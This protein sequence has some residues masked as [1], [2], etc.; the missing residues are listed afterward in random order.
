MS[1]R[2]I[3][4]R[5][6]ISE[7]TAR[8]HVQNIL[9]KLDVSTRAAAAAFAV[10]HGL[11][12]RHSARLLMF[13]QCRPRREYVGASA[14]YVDSSSLLPRR[15]SADQ[16]MCDRLRGRTMAVG[17]MRRTQP[18]DRHRQPAATEARHDL[19]QPLPR[20]RDPRRSADALHPAAC[21][22][23]GRQAGADRR[24]ERPDADLR[25]TGRRRAARGRRVWRG[26]GFRKGDVFAT[27]CP[28]VPE[29]ALAFYGVAS[30]GGATTMLN[31][32][33]TAGEMHR[34]LADSGARFV[35]TVPERLATVREAV[36]GTRVEEIFVLG[37]AEGAT[38]F[39]ALLQHDEPLP[40]VAIDPAEDVVAPALFERHDRPRQGGDADPPQP[41]R[42]R[43]D[44][45]SDCSRCRKT[46]RSSCVSPLF[47][48][49]GISM[50][51]SS[52]HA[53]ATLV[54]M[55]RFDLQTFLRILQ[56]YRATRADLPPP[57]VLE[58][59]RHPIVAEYDLSRLRLILWGAAPMGEAVA[60][61][62][63]SASAAA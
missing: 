51:N 9:A 26:A 35:L 14:H 11:I 13:R 54:L 59:S 40:P 15:K 33:F 63:A 38:P 22:A 30:L 25:A 60:A 52:L 7:R 29:F 44:A 49:A 32:L 50:L 16:P 42:Q 39:Q 43:A 62:A 41:D 18:I 47:H 48:I 21:R 27:V 5:L 10:E 58:L 1:N 23:A 24:P 37:E 3:G 6:F 34:Q 31:P 17:S 57:I 8:T 45:A 4:E 55:P 36:A 12:E 56:D 46:T 28:N 20:R 2:E 61:P 19:P 53:G